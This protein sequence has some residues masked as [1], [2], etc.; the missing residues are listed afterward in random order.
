MYSRACDSGITELAFDFL[1]IMFLRYASERACI[2][3]FSNGFDDCVL[4]M[5]LE[6]STF[7]FSILGQNVWWLALNVKLDFLY[8]WNRGCMMTCST[9]VLR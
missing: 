8:D 2:C 3:G 9:H 1:M 4:L 5:Y 6:A 7:W